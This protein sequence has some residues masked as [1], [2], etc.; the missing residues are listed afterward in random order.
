MAA[1]CT[2]TTRCTC[3]AWEITVELHRPV[4]GRVRAVTSSDMLSGG[5]SASAFVIAVTIL[6]TEVLI[7]GLLTRA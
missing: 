7:M 6:M 1:G 3:G 2:I 4:A 5:T